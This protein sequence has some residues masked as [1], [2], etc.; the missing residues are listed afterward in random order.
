MA[1][2]RPKA[3]EPFFQYFSLFLLA[4]VLFGFGGRAILRYNDFYPP[5]L[6]VMLHAGF[7]LA[8][9]FLVPFQASLVRGHSM[10]RHKRFGVIS[11][12][13]AAGLVYSGA[14][15]AGRHFVIHA[16]P[17]LVLANAQ[18]VFAFAVLYALGFVGRRVP[19]AH[20]R[21]MIYASI[22]ALPPALARVFETV[23]LSPFLAIPAFFLLALVP[24]WYDWRKHKTVY[25]ATSISA[26]FLIAGLLVVAAIGMN[27][28]WA[29]YLAS[30]RT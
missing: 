5:A 29:N 13:I 22:A 14:Y 4:I 10:I 6:P 16:D 27:P 8:W 18:N 19:R 1:K 15:V 24:V 17:F 26:T 3:G 7:M 9:Y 21:F 28:A 30:L 23:G 12:A 11:L 25:I 20:K 2:R